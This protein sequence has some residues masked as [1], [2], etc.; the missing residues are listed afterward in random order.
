LLSPASQCAYTF[1]FTE[2][3]TSQDCSFV[4]KAEIH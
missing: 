2:K 1:I 4:P 3:R